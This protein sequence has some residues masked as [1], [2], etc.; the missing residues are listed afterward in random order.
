MRPLALALVG[1]AFLSMSGSAMGQ[2]RF[3]FEA[4][5]GVEP[6]DMEL[7]KQTARE[8]MDGKEVG[9]RLTWQNPETGNRGVVALLERTESA[10]LECRLNRHSVELVDLDRRVALEF[11]ICRRPGGEWQVYQ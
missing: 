9:T 11:K 6:S 7:M 10:E 5:D 4:L 8:R 2:W 1:I 3:M